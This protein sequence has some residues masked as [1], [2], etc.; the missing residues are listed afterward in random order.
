MEMEQQTTLAATLEDESA[1]AFD[2]TVAR[3]WRV[4]WILLIVTLVEIALA[5]VHY[6]FGVPPVLLRNVIFLSLTLV[7]AFYI[8]AEFMHL[9]HEVKNLILSVMIPLLLFIW[10]ITAFLTDGNSWRVDRERRVTQTE[11]VTPAP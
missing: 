3:I 1:H 5:T 10:F 6:I 7:K 11:Q 2:S 4:F 8:V 9:R